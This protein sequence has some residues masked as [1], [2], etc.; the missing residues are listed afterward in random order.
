MA[1]IARIVAPGYPHLITQISNI[2]KN[3]FPDDESRQMYLNLLHEF[4]AEHKLDIYAYALLEDS[5]HIVAVPKSAESLA[6]SMRR[7]H[8]TYGRE[9]SPKKGKGSSIWI[10]R[11]Q[12]CPVSKPW[13]WPAIKYTERAPLE[14]KLTT[15]MDTYK[16]SSAPAHTKSKKD[17]LLAK[18]GTPKDHQNWLN[19][20]KEPLEDWE[21]DLL[22]A[23][24]KRGYPLGDEQF[25]DKVM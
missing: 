21:Y 23:H 17:P 16:W 8:S 3:V 10:S 7:T 14:Q 25:V 15:R 19:W 6:M 11:Y 9:L 2:G 20:L 24:C 4:S 5:V 13:M 1:R 22:V 12:S 18:V